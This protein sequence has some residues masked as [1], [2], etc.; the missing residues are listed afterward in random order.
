LT[1][2]KIIA[3]A[4]FIGGQMSWRAGPSNNFFLK[5]FFDTLLK[6]EANIIFFKNGNKQICEKKISL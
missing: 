1:K 4:L 3:R 5:F 2:F 6:K